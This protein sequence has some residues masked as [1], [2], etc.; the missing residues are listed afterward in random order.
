MPDRSRRRPRDVNSLA[1]SIV[2]DATDE[3]RPPSPDPDEGKDP[4]AVSLGRRG[5]LKGGRARADNVRATVNRVAGCSTRESGA[6]QRAAELPHSILY[7][8]ELEVTR[9]RVD[10]ST[11]AR[12]ERASRARVSPAGRT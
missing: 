3:V 1:A 6:S 9:A 12:V 11:D 4:A 2:N 8:D 5:G 7:H 10:S